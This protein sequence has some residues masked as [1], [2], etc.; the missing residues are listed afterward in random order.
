M[1]KK[2]PAIQE[3]QVR[4]LGREDPQ[5]KEWQPIL[6]LLPGESHGQRSLVGYSSWGRKDSDMTER[7]THGPYS[8]NPQVNMRASHTWIWSFRDPSFFC[9]VA[10]LVL[11]F[12]PLSQ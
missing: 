7:L 12:Y 8:L 4:S 1:V 9:L 11:Q 10:S 3:A 5:R 6:V 2:L